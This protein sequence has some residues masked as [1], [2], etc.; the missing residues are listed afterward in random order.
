MRRREL[1]KIKETLPGLCPRCRHSQIMKA[2]NGDIRVICNQEYKLNILAPIVE[3]NQF[4]DANHTGKW[5]MEKI[6]WILD[7]SKRTIGFIK[8][9]TE[10]HTKLIRG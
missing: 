8:P 7:T 3:C 6:A 2:V 9:G 1:F 5:E 4:F 10:E